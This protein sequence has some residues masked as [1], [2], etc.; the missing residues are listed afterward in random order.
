MCQ[1]SDLA[2]RTATGNLL[3]SESHIPL[4]G[5][6]HSNA[7]Q[8]IPAHF[9]DGIFRTIHRVMPL[10]L[11]SGSQASAILL[12][13]QLICGCYEELCGSGNR[14]D[15]M[16]YD[17]MGLAAFPSGKDV[18]LEKFIA[19]GNGEGQGLQA[20]VFWTIERRHHGYGLL[21][22]S[23]CIAESLAENHPQMS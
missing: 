18:T 12:S 3:Y 6:R 1:P 10:P 16:M 15:K 20:I 21:P 7:G 23:S 11:M 19:R 4:K 2:D 8:W 5:A 14:N 17:K 22:L 13:A 9:L